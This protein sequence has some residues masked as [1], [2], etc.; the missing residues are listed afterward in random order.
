MNAG[1]ALPPVVETVRLTLRAP[2]LDDVPDMVALANNPKMVETT[3][4]L[5]FPFVQSDG[6]E[7]VAKANSPG[8]R[9]YAIAGPDGRFMGTILFK[10]VDGKHPEI[11][12]WLGEPHWGQGYAA[13][14]VKGLIAAVA[15]LPAFATINA[16][17]LKSNPASVR[18]LEK[19]GF[20]VIEHT[21]SVVERHRGKP[22]L[23][24][25]WSAP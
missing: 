25:Q 6:A 11:G 22:L 13:E 10:L 18:V 9:A 5:P 2:V 19:A 15:H 4:T 21:S 20:V 8:Q 14:A 7:A 12:Y 16:R 3:A 23:V 17:V 24:M 1:T